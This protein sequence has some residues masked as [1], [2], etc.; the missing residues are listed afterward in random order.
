MKIKSLSFGSIVID[1]KKFNEDIV[2]EKG[3]IKIRNKNAS[4]KYKKN[5]GHTPLTIE[6]NIPWDCQTLV[7]AKGFYG[8]LPIAKDVLKEAEKRKVEIKIV[9]TE[10]LKELFESFDIS[11]TNFLIHLTC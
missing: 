5:Y 7:I 1:G 9:K 2:I 3:E 8:A 6:E 11:K 10:Q 4:R